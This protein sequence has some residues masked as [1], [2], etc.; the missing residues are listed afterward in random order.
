MSN[1]ELLTQ[2]TARTGGNAGRRY[3]KDEN[4]E[5]Y[6][7]TT[8]AYKTYAINLSDAIK[9]AFQLAIRQA[10]SG[11]KGTVLNIPI[12]V[13]KKDGVVQFKPDGNVKVVGKDEGGGLFKFNGYDIAD[14]IKFLVRLVREMPIFA[15]YVGKPI[16]PK[17]R[18]IEFKG[19]PYQ[20][21]RLSPALVAF[22]NNADFG[23]TADDN[24][25][26]ASQF[27]ELGNG[28]GMSNT[29]L[30]ACYAYVHNNKSAQVKGQGSFT[31]I[32]KHI[33]DTLGSLPS[34]WSYDKYKNKRP[35]AGENTL[36]ILR[37]AA[38]P[39]KV[40]R[41]EFTTVTASNGRTQQRG[42]NDE[43]FSNNLWKNIISLNTYS[44]KE[45]P[46]NVDAGDDVTRLNL[47]E[48]SPE[49]GEFEDFA[50][51]LVLDH[52]M[53]AR[54]SE[55]NKV[56]VE[57]RRRQERSRP[58]YRAQTNARKVEND[59]Y[60]LYYET[61]RTK[62]DKD[63][64]RRQT[65]A[66]LKKKSDKLDAAGLSVGAVL[67]TIVA[68]Y[69]RAVEKETAK[70]KAIQTGARAQQAK[71]IDKF[72]KAHG[73]TYERPSRSRSRSRSRSASRSASRSSSRSASPAGSPR[74]R[75]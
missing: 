26:L 35:N 70:S 74:R 24:K 25:R 13:V 5:I 39:N 68:R 72:E 61:M 66:L 51:N 14:M 47:R 20:P 32:D 36:D 31:R 9:I 64:A 56:A 62:S 17:A 45:I 19:S 34:F 6:G 57:K 42:I 4:R 28:Y 60:K 49:F 27:R 41:F 37:N 7:I 15:K 48:I 1:Y 16:K 44:F 10:R 63:E 40:K 8:Q 55:A 69:D 46:D 71:K 67:E 21:L 11:K 18:P 50:I 33:N 73:L 43:M 52:D 38:F 3:T 29:I 23:R 12:E 58:E 30:M 54:V 59:G 22:F 75:R 2:R 65:R 53:L